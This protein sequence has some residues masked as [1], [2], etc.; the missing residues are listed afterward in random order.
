[1]KTLNRIATL[2]M[3]VFASVGIAQD[4]TLYVGTYTRGP[5][6]GIYAYKFD[7]ATGK[8]TSVGLA[9]ETSNPSF[10]AVHPSQRFLY[11]VNENDNGTVSAFAV[12][13]AGKLKALNQVSSKGSGPCHL[14]VD[15]TGKWLFVANYN[16]G[17]VAAYP[18]NADGSLV[19]ATATFQHAGKSV[20]AERQSGPHAHVATIS[21]DNRFVWVCDLGLD[22]VRSYRIDPAK[23]MTPNNPPFAKVEPGAGP[24]HVVFRADSKFAYVENEMAAAVTV[25]SYDADKGVMNPLQVIST[26]PEGYTGTKSGAEIAIHPS[27]KFLYTSNRGHNSIAIFKMVTPTGTLFFT[28]TVPTE[29]K[30]P[31]N[32]VIDPT[33]NYLF[34]ANQDSNNIVAFKID[35]QTGG[36]TPTGDKYDVG[37]PVCLVFLST[38][39]AATGR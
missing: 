21:P 14:S 33:G 22:E 9:G 25:F 10:L 38:A 24:R 1:M 11:A 32:F 13:P 16:N 23:G 15:H 6:K 26:L 29:G 30:T 36:L 31:R 35:Q 17:S 37:A 27:S 2:L 20:N 34:A 4:W 8:L 28:G 3:T 7:H 12:D 5:S 39:R 19:E 18:I